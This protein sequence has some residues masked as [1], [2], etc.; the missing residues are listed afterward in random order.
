MKKVLLSLAL[1]ALF[2]SCNTTKPEVVIPQNEDLHVSI[3]TSV[4]PLTRTTINKENVAFTNGD[5]VGVFETTTNVATAV[6][7]TYNGSVWTPGTPMY[8]KDKTTAHN[9]YAFYPYFAAND[10]N[11]VQMP[12][13]AAQTGD[14]AG[15]ALC[16]F[17]YATPVMNKTYA[18]SV[19]LAFKHASALIVLNVKSTAS[20]EG[21]EFTSFTLGKDASNIATQYAYDI[22][23]PALVTTGATAVNTLTVTPAAG[24]TLSG[25]GST[26][27][28]VVN[29]QTP[30]GLELNMT[31][32][33]G[34]MAYSV[35]GILEVPDAAEKF[36]AG[37]V[38]SYN[39]TVDMTAVS[40]GNLSIGS[41]T[42]VDGGDIVA[43]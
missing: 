14:V 13:L 11:A 33:K 38:Y 31:F 6:D 16:D 26:Y 20:A 35:K 9:F 12:A 41:W 15:L 43:N 30:D 23:I 34:G 24:A 28:V 8:W 36:V 42:P 40:L 17:L 3:T 22:T 27:Y 18:S 29:D 4:K 32:T 19:D 39:V 5:K 2:A 37:S 7:W 10:A 1:I 25:A 21:G